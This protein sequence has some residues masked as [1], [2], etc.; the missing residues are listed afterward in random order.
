MDRLD[1]Y[2]KYGRVCARHNE[3]RKVKNKNYTTKGAL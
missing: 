1:L 3:H 2:L